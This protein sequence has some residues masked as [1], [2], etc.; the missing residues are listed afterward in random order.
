MP[1][2]EL[3][4]VSTPPT[5]DGNF[6]VLEWGNTPLFQFQPEN[7]GSRLV[8]VYFVRD[9]THLYMAFLINDQTQDPSDSLRIYFDTTNNGGDP[10]TSDR[11]F[12]IG[13]DGSLQISAGIGS[14]SDG[15]GWNPGY[16]S[17]NWNAAVGEGAGQ[18]WVAEVEINAAAEMGALTDLFGMM[19]QVI[20]TG[21]M[22]VWPED[23]DTLNANTWQ[24]VQNIS[25]PANGE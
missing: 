4:C 1:P 22:A 2:P 7:N 12:Q 14:N 13:R 23:S 19:V 11:A 25:C 24:D 5:I 8:Q 20:Y 10:D 16:T 18:Q 17:D 15:N 6:S 3:S 21:E 9:A